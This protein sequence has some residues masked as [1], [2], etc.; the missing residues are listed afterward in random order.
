M[1]KKRVGKKPKMIYPT[2]WTE[3]ENGVSDLLV[4]KDNGGQWSD[5][6]T[7]L[8]VLAYGIHP[9]SFDGEK[10]IVLCLVQEKHYAVNINV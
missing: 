1:P 10:P 7:A 2:G 8:Y 6:V 5:F 9:D 3:F 4:L